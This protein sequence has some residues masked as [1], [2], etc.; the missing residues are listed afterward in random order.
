MKNLQI[1]HDDP[2]QHRNRVIDLIFDDSK[3]D[4]FNEIIQRHKIKNE[5]A[6]DHSM[7]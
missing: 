2:C 7:R 4:A 1:N 3:N 6:F 5:A